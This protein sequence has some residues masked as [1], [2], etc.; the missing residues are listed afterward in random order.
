MDDQ[1]HTQKLAHIGFATLELI[2][3]GAIKHL[4]T[5]TRSLELATRGIFAKFISPGIISDTNG[6][7]TF[8]LDTKNAN[9]NYWGSSMFATSNAVDGGHTKVTVP[10]F[11]LRGFFDEIGV[12][13][14]D[15]VVL[16]MNAEGGEFLAIPQA[17]QDG[18]LC[19]YVDH[20]TLDIHHKLQPKG[21]HLFDGSDLLEWTKN[22]TTLKTITVW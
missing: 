11:T 4:H 21:V 16:H 13:P 3:R 7:E 17:I 12:N 8:Y 2:L 6:R 18:S 14:A 10:S 15:L 9:V 22:C 20:L 1:R 19:D 5:E